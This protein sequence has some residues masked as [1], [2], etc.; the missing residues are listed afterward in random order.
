MTASLRML[1][2]PPILRQRRLMQT[3]T[4]FFER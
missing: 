4:P 2:D 3:K 1:G